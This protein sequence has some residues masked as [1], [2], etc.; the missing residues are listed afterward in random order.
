[1]PDDRCEIAYVRVIEDDEESL[2]VAPVGAT[3]RD[4]LREGDHSP[5]TRLTERANCGG[6]GLCGTCGVRVREGPAPDH[7]HDDLAGRWG[8]P[9]ISC[10]ITV[11]D[12]MTVEIP[13]KVVWGRREPGWF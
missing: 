1:M 11:E 10:Q 6:R 3:L 5:Y 12:D 4:V 8:Y 2:L 9:R 13:E 7:W